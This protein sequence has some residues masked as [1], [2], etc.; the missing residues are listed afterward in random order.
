MPAHIVPIFHVSILVLIFMVSEV[1]AEP[2]L[3]VLRF[4]TR[5]ILTPVVVTIPHVVIRRRCSEGTSWK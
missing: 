1:V 4:D 5:R 2:V 3:L